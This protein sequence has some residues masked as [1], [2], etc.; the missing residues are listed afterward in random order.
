MF[1]TPTAFVPLD[2][3]SILFFINI[4]Y[5][6]CVGFDVTAS[7]EVCTVLAT[8]NPMMHFEDQSLN[9]T[10]MERKTLAG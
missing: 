10:Y 8:K 3:V 1:E 4:R 5:G 2:K 7:L 9:I 6:I